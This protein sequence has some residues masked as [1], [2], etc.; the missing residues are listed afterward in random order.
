MFRY[1]R[2]GS[3]SPTHPTLLEEI[4]IYFVAHCFCVLQLKYST[5]KTSSRHL[6]NLCQGRFSASMDAVL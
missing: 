2:N 1:V 4:L 3:M 6:F 5:I